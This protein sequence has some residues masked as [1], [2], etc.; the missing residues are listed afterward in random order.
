MKR[1]LILLLMFL[2]LVFS[3]TFAQKPERVEPPNWWTNM[4]DGSLQLLIYGKDIGKTSATLSYPGVVVRK[5]V[6][7]ENPNYLFLYLSINRDAKPGKFKVSLNT[8]GKEVSSFNYELK[9]RVAGS[10][11]R[12][13]FGS[14]DVIYLLMP[15]RFANGDPSNDYQKGY[16]DT[17]NRKDPNARHGGDIKGI[18]EHID[19]IK[20]LGATAVWIN[21][22]DENNMNR[23]SYHGYAITDFYKTD[24]RF[25]SNEDYQKLVA[26]FHAN[27]IKVIKDMVFNHCGSNHWWMADLPSKDWINQWPEFTRSSFRASTISDPHGTAIDRKYMVNGWFDKTMPDLNQRNPLLADY[28]IQNSIWWIEYA[29]LDG[30]RMDTY[31]YPDA[32]FM[33]YWDQRVLLEY[34]NFNIV[35]EVW[36][37]QPSWCAY[38]QANSPEAGKFNSNLPSVMD[39]PLTFAMEKAFDEPSG[40]DT[41][42]MRLYD[43]LSQDF[44][45]ANLNN[46]M[47]FAVNH[48]LSRFFK[49]KEQVDINRYKL[50][51]TFLL[52]TRGIPQVYYGEEMLMYGDKA[53]GDGTIR[54]D[55]PGGWKADTIND[56]IR[57]GRTPLQNEAYDFF[58]TLANWRKGSSALTQGKLI[59]YVPQD[60]VYTYFRISPQQVVMVVLNSGKE[61]K[62]VDPIRFKES[63][64]N[65]KVGVDILTKMHVDLSKP[66]TIPARSEMVLLLQN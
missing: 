38:W 48:D 11:E 43:I 36:M 40:W 22:L 65:Y 61:L 32:D 50:A 57:E 60:N 17:V 7:T 15:D 24:P 53:N 14:E 2:A 3:S 23:T 55:F 21:P 8:N 5:E 4:K 56:F 39:F 6:R 64:G 29:G 52:T 30:I 35:G 28:L 16:K 33:S 47:V 20:N 9:Q 66:F 31:P 41:G 26:Q 59:Q 10:A 12:K 1:K 27:G 49:T 19:Y 63:I 58:S 42:L 62:E 44:L 54:Q 37:S 13:G 18:A 51:M 34:P 25:G 45:Y 46:I